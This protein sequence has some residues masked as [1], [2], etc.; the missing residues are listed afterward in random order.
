MTRAK[1]LLDL[2]LW[3]IERHRWSEAVLVLET[4]K[5]ELPELMKG[6]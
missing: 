3:L 5:A 1:D 2:V 4:L 6:N